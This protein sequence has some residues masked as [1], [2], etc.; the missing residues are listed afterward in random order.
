MAKFT[1]E[2]TIKTFDPYQASILFWF[3]EGLSN[4][5][6]ASKLGYSTSWVVWITGEIYFKLGLDKKDANGKKLHW[7]ARRRILREKVCPIIKRLTNDNPDF[8]ERFPLI[9]PNVLDG[10]ILDL[11]PEIPVPPSE[12]YIPPPEPPSEP[13]QL[14]EPG[15]IPPPE[16]PP[17]FY[18]I[19][20]YNAWLAALEDHRHGKKDT[21]DNPP[22]PSP[23][24]PAKRP[25]LWR[26]ILGLGFIALLGC[27]CVGVLAFWFGRQDANPFPFLPG[28]D[29]TLFFDEFTN[30]KSDR[31]QTIHG[32]GL[33]VNNQLT[34]NEA[35]LMV[36]DEQWTDVEVSFDVSSMQ[37]QGGVGQRG[38][39]IGLRYQ[40]PTNMVKLRIYH[41]DDCAATWILVVN[42]KDEEL[43]NST[44]QLPPRDS[45]GVRHFIMNVQGNTFDSPFGIPVVIENFPTGGVALYADPGVIIDNFKVTRY[46]P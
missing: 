46:N 32:N 11:R 7:T 34:F 26:R 29:S 21:G 13:P 10:H 3:C 18:P 41:Q 2:D 27:L 33:V 45:N 19:E 30:G 38:V 20:L 12:P 39:N 4:D 37:C 8:L 36:L 40:D 35:T 6:I 16:P 14:P 42:G 23:L 1:L 25:I 24:P 15:E 5:D 43:S 17:D 28:S 22:L 44:F 9:P 31:W